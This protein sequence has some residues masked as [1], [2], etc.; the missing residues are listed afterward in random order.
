MQCLYLGHIYTRTPPLPQPSF[1]YLIFLFS[2]FSDLCWFSP[3]R[4]WHLWY[5]CNSSSFFFFYTK[6][7]VQYLIEGTM[8]GLTAT[9]SNSNSNFAE[10]I[11]LSPLSLPLKTFKA[12]WSSTWVKWNPEK[13]PWVDW[14]C[15]MASCFGLCRS[16]SLGVSSFCLLWWC[17]TLKSANLGLVHPC[18][19]QCGAATARESKSQMHT[20]AHTHTHHW[21]QIFT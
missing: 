4:S 1:C 10:E 9:T 17:L 3:L 14:Y 18:R 8:L 20:R 5:N 12:H 15:I 7:V 11:K 19:C 13:Q 16:L 21:S 6:V 2:L